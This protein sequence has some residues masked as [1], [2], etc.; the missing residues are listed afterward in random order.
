MNNEKQPVEACECECAFA[1]RIGYA[2]GG[3]YRDQNEGADVSLDKAQA[4]VSLDDAQVNQQQLP[5]AIK[6]TGL[7]ESE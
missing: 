1:R 2:H 4:T 6:K 7:K 5:D 3:Y